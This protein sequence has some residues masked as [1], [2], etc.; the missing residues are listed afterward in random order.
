M[1]SYFVELGVAEKS[2]LKV[3]RDRVLPTLLISNSVS[4]I[5]FSLCT[6]SCNLQKIYEDLNQQNYERI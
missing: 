4:S 2:V 1:N 3:R 6:D 5:S